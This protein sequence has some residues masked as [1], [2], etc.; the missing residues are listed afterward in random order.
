MEPPDSCFD[1]IRSHQQ[2]ISWSSPLEIYPTTT[3]YWKYWAE[4]LPLSCTGPNWNTFALIRWTTRIN[5][6]LDLFLFLWG[7]CSLKLV[8][9]FTFL[10]SSASSTEK[11]IDTRR[12][13]QMYPAQAEILLHMERTA[14]GIGLHVLAHKTEYMCF[15][16]TGDISTR[17]GCSLKLVDS[18]P[19]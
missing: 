12:F 19:S 4:T 2:S 14:A 7:G 16:Q 18:S 8:D 3:K 15:N 10:G 6:W 11:D 13:R 1:L 9:K 17:G 5:T